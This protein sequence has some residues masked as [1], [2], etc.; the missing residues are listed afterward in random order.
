MA[1]S[2]QVDM[3]PIACV[4]LDSSQKCDRHQIDK[5]WSVLYI[6]FC[7]LPIISAAIYPRTLSKKKKTYGMLVVSMPFSNA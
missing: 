7:V 4:S 6:L 2:A 1:C 5:S 3:V